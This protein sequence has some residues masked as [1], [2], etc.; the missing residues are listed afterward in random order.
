MIK[1]IFIVLFFV[2]SGVLLAQKETEFERIN[3]L[4]TTLTTLK[5]T[6]PNLENKVN[7][8][9]TNL[10]LPLFIKTLSKES[11]VNLSI[12]L[13]GVANIVLTHNFTNASVRDIV[14]Y[15]CK[16]YKLTFNVTGNIISLRKFIP[17]PEKPSYIP[18]NILVEYDKGRDLFSIDLRNDSLAVAFKKITDVTGKNLVFSPGLGGKK[19]SGYIKNKS[20]ESAVDK[21]AFSNQ[22]R[23]TKT[24]DDYYLFE[25]DGEIA[26][27][28]SQRI[29]NGRNGGI[30]KPKRY[31]ESN[32]FFKVKDSVKQL[33]DVDFENIKTGSV[34]KDIANELNV[35]MFTN[36]PLNNIGMASVKANNITFDK[37]LEK[38][39]EDKK[40]TFKKKDGVYY[41]GEETQ[42]SLKT[43]AII[44]LMHRSIE[45]M[46]QPMQSRTNR[47]SFSPGYNTGGIYTS[48]TNNFNN[49]NQ[50]FNG[51]RNFNNN[52][53]NFNNNRRNVPTQNSNF[54]SYSSKSEALINIIPKDIT[55]GLDVQTDRELN[56][57]VVTGD[58]QKVERFKDFI[59]KIDKPVP[60]ILIEVMILEVQKSATVSA[61]VE[62]GLGK[63]PTT[64]QGTLFSATDLT[65]GATS[66][67]KI[68]GGFKGFGS[69]NIGR[70]VPNFYA[71]I[72]AMES[73]GNVKIRS[74]PKLSTLNGHQATLSNGQRKYYAVTRRDIIGSQNPQTSEIKNYVP[75]DADL[76]I[77]IKPMVSGNEQ[78]TMSINVVQSNFNGER[79]EPEA[80]PGMN[81][82]EFNSTIRVRDQDVIIL[83][84]LE[85]NLKNDS[86]RGVP[87][88]SRVPVIKWLFSKK[89]RTDSKTKLSVL[90][91]PTI[92]R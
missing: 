74:T 71:K 21:L 77:A 73:N 69:K 25:N 37:L 79:I 29:R 31:R 62:L 72:Q 14:L 84:G 32:F 47:N 7:F 34:I 60:V 27:S 70:V 17:V 13:E 76:S 51:N 33:L 30:I 16:E 57:F 53:N 20:F 55:N 19:L 22:L 68:I 49:Q 43:T 88:L 36:A 42:A 58:S 39:L 6:I 28:N 45:V 92:I 61:G 11:K 44:S 9:I 56:S 12:R 63:E 26:S 89:T 40:F 64:D 90:I 80:P 35:N 59:K 78:I 52:S 75:I 48:N 67:N 85:E 66:I 10:K 81:S 41:F 1:K 50:N 8:N 15:L 87:F 46:N 2:Y 18:R 83:G 65:L 24:K 38:L 23:V 82:R 91:K 4:E 5:N 86:G 54:G 3:K